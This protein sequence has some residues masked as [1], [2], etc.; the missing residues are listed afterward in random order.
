MR[1]YFWI[2]NPKY[3][4]KWRFAL[5]TPEGVCSKAQFCTPT[6]T[7]YRNRALNQLSNDNFGL[8]LHV[9]RQIEQKII[10]RQ[11]QDKQDNAYTSMAVLWSQHSFQQQLPSSGCF[12]QAFGSLLQSQAHFECFGQSLCF[13]GAPFT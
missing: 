3:S 12:L 11:S 4:L 13:V 8:M 9:R 1:D 7:V 5:A 6:K 2:S 10:H